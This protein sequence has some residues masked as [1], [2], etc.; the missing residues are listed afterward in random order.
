M[1][2]QTILTQKLEETKI[3][4]AN[5]VN[6]ARA[7]LERL[8]D[9]ENF[10]E[11]YGNHAQYKRIQEIPAFP[12]DY[13]I[14]VIGGTNNALDWKPEINA[15]HPTI[16]GFDFHRG[17]TSFLNCSTET[18]FSRN[19]VTITENEIIIKGDIIPIIDAVDFNR[20]I[21]D[22]RLHIA[23]FKNK[24]AIYA[25]LSNDIR[26]AIRKY[27][28]AINVYNSKVNNSRVSLIANIIN[29]AKQTK[30]TRLDGKTFSLF[31]VG[32]R[33]H[34][35][36]V[37]LWIQST[38]NGVSSCVKHTITKNGDIKL[39]NIMVNTDHIA[40]QILSNQFNA[41]VTLEDEEK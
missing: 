4:L 24:T 26:E 10:R 35:T 19:G 32:N 12:N 15:D 8:F 21:P 18:S 1:E 40:V 28:L 23:A 36:I 34:E 3:Q 39:G 37:E 7:D 5:E 9:V 13:D 27:N 31:S 17:S 29:N 6:E 33:T 14:S 30:I 41:D 38:D 11:V 25:Q 20:L 22:I 2:L 16:E